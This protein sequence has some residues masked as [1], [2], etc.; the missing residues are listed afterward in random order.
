MFYIRP[1]TQDLFNLND[2]GAPLSRPAPASSAF[3][4]PY[5]QGLNPPQREAV[6]TLMGP[7]LVLAGAGTGK[8]R[9]LTTRIAHLLMTGTARP[10]EVLA[11]TFTNKAAGEMRERVEALIG[12]PTTGWWLGTFHSL[13]ARILRIHASAFGVDSFNQN[14]TILV[15]NSLSMISKV[16]SSRATKSPKT[17]RAPLRETA[18]R[19]EV[20]S[21]TAT[22]PV[23]AS[24]G[25]R[26]GYR[27]QAVYPTRVRSDGRHRWP[28]RSGRVRWHP[29]SARLT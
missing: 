4:P 24:P 7:V 23:R 13:A 15:K 5:L 16:T 6:E 3:E 20:V 25:G 29:R 1:M 19:L 14:F 21:V 9:A 26:V 28:R 22:Q 27:P 11:V 8:T 10:Q 12:Q 18:G 17:F 2:E